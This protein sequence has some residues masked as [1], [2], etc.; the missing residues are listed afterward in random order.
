MSALTS[1][2]QQKA[3]IR[4][5][6]DC[7][8]RPFMLSYHSNNSVLKVKAICS[9]WVN[10][11]EELKTKSSFSYFNIAQNQAVPYVFFPFRISIYD[12]QKVI[13]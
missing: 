5:E 12:T 1:A 3:E 8:E 7:N 9:H 11:F 6:K 4:P 2:K 10:V 13:L